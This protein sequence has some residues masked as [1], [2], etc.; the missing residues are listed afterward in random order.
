MGFSD[1]EHKTEL[2]VDKSFNKNILLIHLF[3]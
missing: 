2:N 1:D 3:F